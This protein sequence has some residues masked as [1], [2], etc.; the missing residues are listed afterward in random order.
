MLL[1]PDGLELFF[2]LL[3]GL[4]AAEFGTNFPDLTFMTIAPRLED[5]ASC[6]L[7]IVLDRGGI[8]ASGYVP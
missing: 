7:R 3:T 8:L 6:F 5:A 2:F 1:G 4:G